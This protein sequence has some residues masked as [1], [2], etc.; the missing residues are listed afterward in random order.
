[1]NNESYGLRGVRD[2]ELARWRE[3]EKTALDLLQVAGEL[4]FDRGIDLTLFRQQIYDTRPSEVLRAHET[5][6]QYSK[7][8]IDVDLTLSLAY[9]VAQAEELGAC[10]VDLGRLATEWLETSAEFANMDEFVRTALGRMPNEV[11]VP[12]RT[13]E[14]EGCDVV[15]YGFGRIGRMLTR[16]LAEQTG[17][18]TQLR[19]R[20]IVLRAK[21]EDRHLEVSKRAALLRSDSVHGEFSGL[22]QVSPDADYI[23]ING[24]RIRM[25]FANRP[26]DIDYSGYEIDNAL[27]IDSTGVWRTREG[28]E[29]HLRPG[30]RSVLLTAPGAEVPNIVVGINQAQY[31]WS[32][33]R[34]ASAASCTTNAVAPLL[35]VLHSSLGIQRAHIETVHAYTS[36][37]NLLDNF[38]KKPR[39]GR[40]A[41]INMVLTTT[42]AAR[43]VAKVI[44]ELE[45]RLTGNAVRVPVPNG[46]LAIINV[47]VS[48]EVN[49]DQVNEIM[50]EASLRGP[51]CEQIGYSGSQE[52]VSTGVVGLSSTCVFDAPSTQV[53][54]D[55]KGLTVYGWYDN[56][57]GYTYQVVRLAKI[58]AGV[59]RLRYT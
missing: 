54:Q 8:A 31:D 47:T 16:L 7:R 48:Q 22:V 53:S 2:A 35:Q 12:P 15:L 42:G 44:P 18:G 23:I 36:D 57:G 38:H 17:R 6:L 29:R 39:R 59:H 24:N 1:M 56:E 14:G 10:K 20:A 46:S 45:G 58:M 37:Q 55:G 11:D 41:P 43:A 13:E 3:R 25:V 9:A 4:R 21:L 27:L 30:I 26:E 51:L 50:R 32:T 49:R 28:L 19:L 33:V 52:Y 34:L 40:A 5:S